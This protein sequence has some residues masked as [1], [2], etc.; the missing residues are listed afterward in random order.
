MRAIVIVALLAGCTPRANVPR[1][2]PHD[3][4]PGV[5]IAVCDDGCLAECHDEDSGDLVWPARCRDGV[6][7]A[8]FDDT[9]AV[10]VCR[11]DP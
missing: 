6:P 4:E 1:C 5:R 10:C 3:S 8:E 2:E 9:V 7:C 11:G